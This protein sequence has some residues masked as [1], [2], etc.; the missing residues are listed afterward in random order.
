MTK[1]HPNLSLR[2]QCSLLS[3]ARS[4]LYSPPCVQALRQAGCD[5]TVVLDSSA[6]AHVVAAAKIL[7]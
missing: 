5:L 2:R 1:D 7:R 3:L 6:Q 4:S